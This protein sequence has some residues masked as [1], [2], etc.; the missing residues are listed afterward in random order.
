LPESPIDIPIV[1]AFSSTAFVGIATIFILM[2]I[3]EVVEVDVAISMSCFVRLSKPERTDGSW[4][5]GV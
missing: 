2:V 3:E 4:I 1:A 5:Q